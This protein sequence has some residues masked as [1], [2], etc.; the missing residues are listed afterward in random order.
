VASALAGQTTGTAKRA[1]IV[2]V[3]VMNCSQKRISKLA[4]ARGLDWIQADMQSRPG[5][6]A[7]VSMSILFRLGSM[8]YS[9]TNLTSD[10][11]CETAVGAPPNV[12][13][14]SAIEN[15]IQQL[16]EKDIPVVVAAANQDADPCS[17]TNVTS[18]ARLG[19]GGEATFP[20]TYRTITVGGTMYTTTLADRHWQC[21][22]SPASCSTTF[23]TELGS[24]F[25]PCV[26]IWAPA[27]NVRVAYPTDATSY[28][29]LGPA[30][31]GTSF[32]AP[33][34][35]GVV[36]RLLQ[37]YPNINSLQV[38]QELVARANQRVSTPDF[39]RGPTVN[40]KLLYMPATQ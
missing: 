11:M 9:G 25:G 7:V 38:W 37:R 24:N 30:S 35:A 16:V 20:A 39:D 10:E 12:N 36:A 17:G 27:M 23:A 15:E 8:N 5:T 33:L 13:C 1:T 6:R 29:P 34:T 31:S 4:V 40:T 19:Y 32:A 18:P 22:V 28:R 2:P 3:K 26:S 14:V 21:S